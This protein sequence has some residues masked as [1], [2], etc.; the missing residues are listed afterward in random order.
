MTNENRELQALRKLRNGLI[1]FYERQSW[2][3]YAQAVW[4]ECARE[5]NSMGALEGCTPQPG[6]CNP[7]A[8][9]EDSVDG[10]AIIKIFSTANYYYPVMLDANGSRI[11]LCRHEHETEALAGKCGKRLVKRALGKKAAKVKEVPGV[12]TSWGLACAKCNTQV[13]TKEGKPYCP[14]H[15]FVKHSEV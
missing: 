9:P 4:E 7:V 2:P 15:G 8:P 11:A 12:A 14:E 10:T 13:V 5:L 6:N 1:E 3:T